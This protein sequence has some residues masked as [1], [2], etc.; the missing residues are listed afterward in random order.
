M[1][2]WK[3]IIIYFPTLICINFLQRHTELSL[4]TFISDNKSIIVIKQLGPALCP[5]AMQNTFIKFLNKII[6]VLV[7]NMIKNLHI[8]NQNID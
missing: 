6:V 7:N 1:L 2:S 8:R 5:G 3:L 4:D